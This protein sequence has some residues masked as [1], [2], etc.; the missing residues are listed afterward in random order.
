[1][2]GKIGL[3]VLC[4]LLPFASYADNERTLSQ[5]LTYYCATTDMEYQESVRID[6][7]SRVSIL[8]GFSVLQVQSQPELTPDKH[9]IKNELLK[10]GVKGE[11]AEFL[12]TQGTS[13]NVNARVY[14][15]FNRSD[16]TSE[17]IYVLDT[18][19]KQI[20]DQ[21]PK[22]LINGY[23]DSIGS[24]EYNFSLGMRRAESVKGYLV[25]NEKIDAKEITTHSYGET[26][27]IAS[28]K[29]VEGRRQNRR[30]EIAQE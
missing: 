24:K 8:Q 14:F 10:I 9:L 15:N 29:T 18:L 13:S 16:L 26:K 11:C 6:A 28:N 20:Q 5:D 23:T 22:L 17:S 3:V 21:S 27:P 1:M 25:S 7:G 30:V 4:S 12:L 2:K 19:L